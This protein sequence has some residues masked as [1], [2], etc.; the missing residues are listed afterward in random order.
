[1]DHVMMAYQVKE[2]EQVKFGSCDDN[3]HGG[4][5]CISKWL[6]TQRLRDIA[7][8]VVRRYGGL[9]L[10]FDRFKLIEGAASSAVQI[11]RPD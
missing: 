5:G 8:F 3:E 7:V 4:G 9:H 11:L 2:G 10:G 6:Y 1:M